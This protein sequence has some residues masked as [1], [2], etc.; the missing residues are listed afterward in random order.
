MF[1]PVSKI[2]SLKCFAGGSVSNPRGRLHGQLPFASFVG[3]QGSG[4]RPED[5]QGRSTGRWAVPR[6]GG[7]RW[8]VASLKSVQQI[9]GQKW[10]A[11]ARNDRRSHVILLMI[12]YVV[13][14]HNLLCFNTWKHDKQCRCFL[15]VHHNPRWWIDSCFRAFLLVESINQHASKWFVGVLS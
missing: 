10:M 3:V 4:L 15:I 6:V 12:C 2:T 7:P 14:F 13:S 11:G 5:F 1:R 9:L 8:H